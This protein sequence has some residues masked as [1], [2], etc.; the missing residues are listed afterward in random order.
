MA[1]ELQAHNV[2]LVTAGHM[3]IIVGTIY[4]PTDHPVENAGVGFDV[5]ERGRIIAHEVVQVPTLEAGQAWR[6]AWPL[7]TTSQA[8]V[9]QVK[10][11]DGENLRIV[12]DV[13]QAPSVLV[14]Q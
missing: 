7:R 13:K 2:A 1:A 4:N 14:K 12:I 6:L 11:T 5:T 10:A 8:A 3:N 9:T